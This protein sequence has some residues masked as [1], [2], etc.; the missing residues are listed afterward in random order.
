MRREGD[1]VRRSGRHASQAAAAGASSNVDA[2]ARLRRVLGRIVGHR[3]A[4]GRHLTFVM[5][6]A[7]QAARMIVADTGVRTQRHDA[8]VKNTAAIPNVH[9]LAMLCTPNDR[10]W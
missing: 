7:G 4:V 2:V 8:D 5:N 6:A 10:Q 1:E 3:A 9:T